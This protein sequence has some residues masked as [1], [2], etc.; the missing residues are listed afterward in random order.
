ML[1]MIIS[2]AG[3]SVAIAAYLYGKYKPILHD[4][5]FYKA[6]G[7]SSLGWKQFIHKAR[8][9]TVKRWRKMD[10]LKRKSLQK[11]VYSFEQLQL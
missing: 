2:L 9:W 10:I 6:A 3:D 8:R 4:D 5:F 11:N 7:W 1:K